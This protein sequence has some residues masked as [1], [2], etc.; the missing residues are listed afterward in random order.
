VLFR[1]EYYLSPNNAKIKSLIETN[2]KSTAT[3]KKLFKERRDVSYKLIS[4]L[5]ISLI[6]SK[7]DKIL[8]V[9]TMKMKKR[10]KI[11]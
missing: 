9:R 5:T 6:I 3:I 4:L 8:K 7:L 11:D 1:N 2:S 10:M